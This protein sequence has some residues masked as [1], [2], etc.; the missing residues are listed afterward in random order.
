MS[1]LPFPL[2]IPAAAA[3][4]S[5]AWFALLWAPAAAVPADFAVAFT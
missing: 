5:F 2:A 1:T 4:S 3:A